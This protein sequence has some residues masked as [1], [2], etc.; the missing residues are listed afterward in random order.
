MSTI[1]DLRK[2][3]AMSNLSPATQKALTSIREYLEGHLPEGPP[4][5]FTS[6]TL[7]A[8]N[9]VSDEMILEGVFEPPA[10]HLA[11][12]H[13]ATVVM[14]GSETQDGQVG[15]VS[16]DLTSG[17]FSASWKPYPTPVEPNPAPINVSGIVNCVASHPEANQISLGDFLFV[18][19]Q[20]KYGG[21]FY[22]LMT[23]NN[24]V[25]AG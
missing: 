6:F 23:S 8:L 17:D 2:R 15:T 4:N 24:N 14:V 19:P 9:E 22:V 18:I 7:V 11:M 12:E 3:N 21:S 25:A 16:L 20:E 13:D 1:A 10:G 5:T